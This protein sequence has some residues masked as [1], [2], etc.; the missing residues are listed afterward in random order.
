[1]DK[2]F[3]SQKRRL[4]KRN[5]DTKGQ[6]GREKDVNDESDFFNESRAPRYAEKERVRTRPRLFLKDSSDHRIIQLRPRGWGSKILIIVGR[7][8]S[9][10]N[11][12]DRLIARRGTKH[13]GFPVAFSYFSFHQSPVPVCFLSLC[14]NFHRNL[15]YIRISDIYFS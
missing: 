14:C 3:V 9:P 5:K 2:L 4:S 10:A 6:K 7:K 12:L 1:M 11:S 15:S 13:I 8:I